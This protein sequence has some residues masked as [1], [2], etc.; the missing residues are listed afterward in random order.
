METENDWHLGWGFRSG[1]GRGDAID[2]VLPREVAFNFVCKPNPQGDFMKFL[3]F[4]I[5]MILSPLAFG[6]VTVEPSYL[7]T[8]LAF[9][10]AHPVSSFSAMF[11]V[12][13]ELL[14]KIWPSAKELSFLI[15]VRYAIHGIRGVFGWLDDLLTQWI[16]FGQNIKP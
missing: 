3:L 12:A 11:G 13:I 5:L 9:L 6:Q 8:I 1:F 7:D 2:V 15:P 10:A 14:L 16:A 4:A